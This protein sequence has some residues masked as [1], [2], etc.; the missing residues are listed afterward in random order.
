MF[1]PGSESG[2]NVMGLLSTD[3]N[4]VQ[5]I[6]VFL[7][8]FNTLCKRNVFFP[9]I[10]QRYKGTC[11]CAPGLDNLVNVLVCVAPGSENVVNVMVC[12]SPYQKLHYGNGFVDP[13][14]ENV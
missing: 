2:V 6:M 10:R 5:K 12:L 3:Y 9:R 4:T 11:Q 8:Q 7:P 13:G 14:S 1:V